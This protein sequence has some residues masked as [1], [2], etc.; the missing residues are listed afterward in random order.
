MIDNFAII[1]EKENH[2][3]NINKSDNKLNVGAFLL[4]AVILISIGT[5]TNSVY[6]V[7]ENKG[8]LRKTRICNKYGTCKTKKATYGEK[9][10]SYTTRAFALFTIILSLITSIIC[11][12]SNKIKILDKFRRYLMVISIVFTFLVYDWVTEI[13]MKLPTSS[14]IP[15]GY[16]FYFLLTGV[17]FIFISGTLEIEKEKKKKIGDKTKSDEKPDEN[18]KTDED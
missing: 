13:L 5:F 4:I 14:K 7:G 2:M 3:A 6:S 1:N 16:S 8:W 11:F 18:V 17:I 15:F 9:I 12:K 10:K